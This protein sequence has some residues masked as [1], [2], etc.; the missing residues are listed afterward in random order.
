MENRNEEHATASSATR[1][2]VKVVR[3]AR[4]GTRRPQPTGMMPLPQIPLPDWHGS[5]HDWH[6]F[7]SRCR[8]GDKAVLINLLFPGHNDQRQ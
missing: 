2:L 6:P 3:R 4:L 8:L 1:W 5:Q 7:A